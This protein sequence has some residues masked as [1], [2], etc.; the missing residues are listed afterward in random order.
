MVLIV[1]W[2]GLRVFGRV[3]EEFSFFIVGGI[4]WEV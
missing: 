2:G 3:S 1:V 4:G